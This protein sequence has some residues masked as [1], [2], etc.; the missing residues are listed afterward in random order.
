MKSELISLYNLAE[1]NNI[2]VDWVDM[3]KA[4]SLS[5]AIPDNTYCIAIDPWKMDTVAK[6]TVCLAH[7]LGH[8]M[9][10]SFYNEYSPFDVIKKHENKADKWAI[11]KIIPK[12]EYVS[13]VSDGCTDIWL[14]AE[15]FGVTEDFMKK[16]V[17]LY[18]HGNLNTGLYF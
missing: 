1:E 16:A 5:V 7:E 8:C 17:C 11:K 13:A 9:T 15:R 14:L 3:E 2:D 18:D 4:E 6:E 12:D 10:G